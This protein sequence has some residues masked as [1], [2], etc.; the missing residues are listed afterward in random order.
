[1][2]VN[3]FLVDFRECVVLVQMFFRLRDDRD[4]AHVNNVTRRRCQNRLIWVYCVKHRGKGKNTGN[5]T[6]L[7]YVKDYA[8]AKFGCLPVVQTKTCHYRPRELPGM[9]TKGPGIPRDLPSFSTFLRFLL[10]TLHSLAPKPYIHPPLAY[11]GKFWVAQPR[12]PGFF[13]LRNV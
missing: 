7:I 5:I 4:L 6:D 10:P 9:G 12:H 13:G 3:N 2:Q 1:M 8:D 11:G